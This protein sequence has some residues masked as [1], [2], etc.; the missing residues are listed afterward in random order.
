MQWRF[1]QSFSPIPGVRLTLSPNG[2]STSVGVGPLRFTAG[3]T[4][5]LAITARIPGTGISFRQPLTNGGSSPAPGIE[6]I[7]TLPAGTPRVPQTPP[8]PAF[9]TPELQDIKSAGSAVLTTPGLAAFKLALHEAQ[10]QHDDISAD[11]KGSRATEDQHG[12]RFRAWQSGWLFRR[13]FKK[14]FAELE[15][16]S[17]DAAARRQELEEQLKLSTLA[18]DIVMPDGV[19]K[20][21][22]RFCDDFCALASSQKIWDNVAARGT[23]RVTE[24]TTANRV[25]DRKEV[26]FRLGKC[27]VI[28]TSM[29][30]PHLQ[31]AN[32]GDL[33]FYPGF[34]VYFASSTN[35]GLVEYTDLQ[36][37]VDDVH[38]QE[39][40]Q[41][42]GD[43]EVI[44]QTW[45]KANKDGSPDRRFANNRQIPVVRYGMLNFKSSTG[46]NEEY[47]V[48][49]WPAVQAIARAWAD[50]QA[51]VKAGS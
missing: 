40:S 18:T 38:F 37:R 21:F 6:P 15:T 31:N 22:A 17:K 32:G 30:V 50:L 51:A 23:N 28:E 12:S 5:G 42:P 2:I 13:L 24:R 49:N 29:P 10:R 3:T 16:L 43:S 46:L 45:T 36:V 9:T 25:I 7:S 44:G 35:F 34:L 11:L 19:A 27:G 4:S 1:R 26:S 20:S 47:M 39:Q 8:R 41:I 14:H 48:S 33:F